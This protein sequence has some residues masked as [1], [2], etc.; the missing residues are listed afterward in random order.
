M[1]ELEILLENADDEE[2]V[3]GSWFH[4]VRNLLNDE[5]PRYGSVKGKRPNLDLDLKGGH[6]GL[7]LDRFW[8]LAD[9]CPGITQF[10][11]LYFESLFERRFHIPRNVFEILCESA[12]MRSAFMSKGEV[13]DC[14]DRHDAS[15]LQ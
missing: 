13:R 10:G 5:E 11:P 7:I 15:A 6:H 12:R 4:M 9:L 1:D 3:C 14:A 8:L 2:L